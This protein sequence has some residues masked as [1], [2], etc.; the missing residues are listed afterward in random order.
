ML[1]LLLALLPSLI[2]I[3]QQT[4]KYLGKAAG[5]KAHIIIDLSRDQGIIIPIWRYLAQ[6]GEEKY[7]FRAVIKEIT[8]LKPLFIRI[9][10]VFDFYN[11]VRKE[12][13]HP[14]FNFQE[15]D[16]M[17]NQILA[18]GAT[19]FFSLSYMP[20]AIAQNHDI[21]DQPDNWLDWSTTVKATIQHYSGKKEKNLNNVIYEIWNEPDLF[22]QWKI[23]GTKDYRLLYY[24]AIIGAN[25]TQETNPFKIGGPAV[26]APYQTWVNGFL[27]YNLDHQLQIDFYSWHRYALEPEA[28]LEDLQKVN[29]WLFNRRQVYLRKYLSEW[30]PVSE[31]SSDY[32]NYFGAAHL[33]AT[34]RQL[35]Q[36][37]DGA[38]IFEIKDGLSPKREK[39]WGRWGL[40]THE[41]AGPVEK[42][43]RYKALLLLNQMGQNRVELRGEGSLVS[44]FATKDGGNIKI[45][46][47]NL[48]RSGRNYE[49]I[50]LDILNLEAGLYIYKE[51]YLLGIGRQMNLNVTGDSLSLQIPLS[52]NNIVLLSLTK[53]P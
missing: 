37:V 14:E 50:P 19:P 38:F 27:D 30:G 24:Y 4:Q 11:V 25:Q 16:E 3:T 34:I 23:G 47:V 52:A 18:T 44:G 1:F 28:F 15:L 49:E 5:Q 13:G 17:V 22:G 36:R 48:D 21:V 41:G 43:P 33:A 31:N 9:D 7:P 29:D 53:T 2:F 10:H 6:G 51:T 39:L 35:L 20:P 46:L 26:T 40:L 12:N 42:K 32:D 8:E 45:F